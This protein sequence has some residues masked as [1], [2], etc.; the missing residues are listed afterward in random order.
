AVLQRGR[1]G[2]GVGLGVGGGVLAAAVAGARD[3]AAGGAT[4]FGEEAERAHGVADAG[5]DIIAYVRQNDVLPNGETQLT[6]AMTVGKI[7]QPVHLGDR[8][9]SNRHADADGAEP[10]LRLLAN[11]EPAML[12]D[13]TA[14]FARGERQAEEREG[15][16]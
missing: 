9:A 4:G 1:E 3:D 12:H 13:R 15:E 5:D 8:E 11:A 14:R 7:G 16:A 2:H 6:A 10:G